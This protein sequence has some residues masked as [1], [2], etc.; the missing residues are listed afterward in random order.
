VANVVDVEFLADFDGGVGGVAVLCFFSGTK[1][2]VQKPLSRNR[3]PL[4]MRKIL[5]RC[6]RHR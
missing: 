4:R 2:P 6:R 5:L 1:L 3:E